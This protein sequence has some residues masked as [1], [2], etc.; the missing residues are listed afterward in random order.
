M[1]KVNKLNVECST[2]F[3]HSF[4]P[5]GHRA[6]WNRHAGIG[7][8]GQA[9][10]PSMRHLPV[11]IPAMALCTCFESMIGTLSQH[12]RIFN[13]LL[14][15]ADAIL[16]D[17]LLARLFDLYHLGFIAQGKD[18]GMAQPVLCLK[19]IVVEEI[20]MGHVAFVAI[21]HLPVG[22]VK[23]RGIL[24][25]HDVTV[26]TCFGSIGQVGMGLGNIKRIPP[27]PHKYS[28]YKHHRHFPFVGRDE[29]AHHIHDKR[30]SPLIQKYR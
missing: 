6:F 29:L 18:R 10:F 15:A 3:Q 17:Y 1:L 8:Q 25:C 23:P 5:F 14:V 2:V 27:Q 13:K 20:V 19:I 24:G 30:L 26:H 28:Q 4:H 21:G 12:F 11:T 16:L 22:A 7:C 9:V